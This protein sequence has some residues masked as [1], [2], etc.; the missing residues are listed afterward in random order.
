MIEL[1]WPWVWVL[2]PL[3]YFIYRLMPAAK[4]PEVALIAPFFERIKTIYTSDVQSTLFA[5][6]TIIS[7]VSVIW[8]LLLAAA[9][10]PQWV[11]DATAV[12]TSARDVMLAVDISGSMEM[13]DLTLDDKP[14]TRLQVIKHIVGEFVQQRKGDRL[15]LILFGTQAYLQAPLTFDL[16]HQTLITPIDLI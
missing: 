13:P 2:L 15:G 3:P 5:Q 8:I 16:I 1:L 12:P 4:R 7:M 6:R 10:R 11:G 9:S 14:V